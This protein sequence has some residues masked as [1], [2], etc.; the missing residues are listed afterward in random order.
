M[1]EGWVRLVTTQKK[2]QTM[3]VRKHLE[4]AIF[5]CL[6]AE[7]KSGDVA[8]L[9]SDAYTDYR[10]QLL[11][12]AECL[13]LL[14]AYC[15]ELE[16][17]TTA[18]AFVADL[19][20]RLSDAARHFDQ[21]FPKND[22]V[23]INDQGEPVLKRTPGREVSPTAEVLESNLIARLPERAL[24][25]MLTNVVS[26][27]NCTRHFGPLSGSDP[28]LKRR[29]PAPGTD[30]PDAHGTID[31]YIYLLFAYGTNMGPTQA[32]RHLRGV[33][34]AHTLS[35]L[36]RRHVTSI[37]LD[38]A[39]AD[40]VNRYAGMRL[41]RSWGDGTRVAVDGTARE[42]WE[43]NPLA[44]YHF[45]YRR[46]GGVAYRH[47]ADTYVAIFSHFIPCGVW[48]AIYIIDGL[49]QNKSEVRPTKVHADTQGQSTTVF[50]LSHLLGIELLPR[51]RN[52][53]DLIFYKA[54]PATTYHHTEM[55]YGGSIDWALIERHW[56][57]MLQVVLSIRAGKLSS[58]MLLRK[59]GND[60]KKNRLYQV[61]RELG[62]VIRTLFLLRYL[63]DKPLRMQITAE[64]NKVESF[65][66]FSNWLTFGR[67]GVIAELDPED[68][69]KVIK[70]GDIL[71]NAVMLH[72]V[73]D[74]TGVLRGMMQERQWV[75]PADLT[76]LSP[77]LTSSI[78]R[79]GDYALPTGEPPALD[80]ILSWEPPGVST[81]E[82]GA[83]VATATR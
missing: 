26:W 24:L 19:K 83:P 29:R 30:D 50:A 25:D 60:S 36:N 15:A 13:S 61:F 68:A 78:K 18:K 46:R 51:I 7:L 27:T 16:L 56:E 32:A 2:G 81:M 3:L 65:H 38:A 22:Q 77:Y 75:D 5:S 73:F 42:L 43:N 48:E 62:R 17:P 66:Q 28:K 71:A 53:K 11:P 55:L 59:L 45:R 63:S 4:P 40:I 72:N 9:G 54:D 69:E 64:T 44:E 58:A 10:D 1:P 39:L 33:V 49:L 31:N 74:M 79:F 23:S 47:I 67:S 12:W 80:D 20:Q 52:W 6:A 70:Y 57:D 35:Y 76:S 37:K 14:P 41:P 8:V 21:S 34:S 82:P